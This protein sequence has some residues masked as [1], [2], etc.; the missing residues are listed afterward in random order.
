MLDKGRSLK[1]VGLSSCVSFQDPAGAVATRTD[2]FL[3]CGESGV[4]EKVRAFL[5]R[6]FMLMKI[7]ETNITHAG[8][9]IFWKK[10]SSI[11]IAQKQSFTNYTYFPRLPDNRRSV[12]DL[13][14]PEE[15]MLDNASRAEYAS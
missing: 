8:M 9:A 2:D 10:D 14:N 5:T 7:R 15:I 13:W 11:A 4:M 1:E 3:G 6:R 12:N